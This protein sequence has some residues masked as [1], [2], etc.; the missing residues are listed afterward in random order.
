MSLKKQG[1]LLAAICAL[2]AVAMRL[3]APGDLFL[4][5]FALPF[6]LV[7]KG[8]RA[9]S[10]SGWAGDALAWALYG[11]LCAL[12]VWQGLWMRRRGRTASHWHARNML[13]AALFFGVYQFINPAGFVDLFGRVALGEGL[14]ICK[15]MLALTIWSFALV[16]WVLC[17]LGR[18]ERLA[19]YDGLGL[20]LK[21]TGGLLIVSLC[22]SRLYE[23]T[24][25]I[26][27][28]GVQFSD[29]SGEALSGMAAM[30]ML[31]SGFSPCTVEWPAAFR[32]L[33]QALPAIYLLLLLAPALS[34]LR[35]LRQDP[36]GEAVPA[37][38][39]AVAQRARAVVYACLVSTVGANLL[40]LLFAEAGGD[41]HINLDVPLLELGLAIALLLFADG[42][43]RNR[44]LKLDN[45]AII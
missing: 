10:L 2:G 25:C 34:L 21:I 28:T 32:I 8:L 22:Y 11:L 37:L 23:L 7:G 5:A 15:S 38:S 20:L 24:G 4:Y 36:Y 35:T 31:G 18:A 41:V 33:A 42:S 45:D 39:D 12:P 3:L 40:Q 16:W 27:S 6:D 26:R 9:L 1:L 30:A 17:M 13:A 14:L 29:E 43:R 44:A 19:L